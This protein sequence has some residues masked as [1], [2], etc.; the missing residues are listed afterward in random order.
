MGD[1]RD[2]TLLIDK[3]SDG[4][5]GVKPTKTG[6]SR[7]VRLL[8]P[9]AA[10]LLRRRLASGRPDDDA[11]VF[12]SPS[13]GVWNDAHWQTWHRDVWRRACEAAGLTGV[14]PYDLRHGFVSLLIQEGRH[15]V[16]VARKP[17]TRRR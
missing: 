4:E 5:G 7:T 2:R 12:P 14:R 3:A 9:L 6:Q 8:G 10:D 15:V 1:V 16:D 17:A 11:L 13:G